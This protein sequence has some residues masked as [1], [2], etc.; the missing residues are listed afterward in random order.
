MTKRTKVF[1][2]IVEKNREYGLAEAIAI[3]KKAP[4]VKFDETVDISFSLNADPKDTSQSL[5][6]TVLLPRGLGKKV[7]IAVFCQGEDVRIAED[8]GADHVGGDELAEKVQNGFLDFDVAIATPEMM[9][10][11]GKLGKVLGPRGLM[12]NPKA[13]TVTKD[14]AKAINEAKAGKVEFKMDKQGDVHVPVGKISFEEDALR[15][16]VMAVA[17]AVNH[18]RPSSAKG[19]FV[20]SCYLSCTMGPGIKLDVNT[21]IE[22]K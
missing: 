18:A 22:G 1:Q 5:R 14:I 11:L 2:E 19:K 20:K 12:P 21:F 13:G 17:E 4:R 9:R 10:V 7:K 3:V 8:A 6:G 15:E 16:N